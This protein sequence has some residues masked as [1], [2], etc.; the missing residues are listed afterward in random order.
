MFE[1]P[2]QNRV[3]PAKSFRIDGLTGIAGQ[4][5]FIQQVLDLLSLFGRQHRQQLSFGGAAV[6]FSH[7][8]IP[9]EPDGR[10]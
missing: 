2:Q 3:F 8:T 6:R 10:R 4:Q 9:A 7:G 1:V 5:V